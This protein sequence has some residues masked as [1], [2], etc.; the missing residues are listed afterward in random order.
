MSD[1]SDC[2]QSIIWLDGS[3]KAARRVRIPLGAQSNIDTMNQGAWNRLTP[4]QQAAVRS[5][6]N[7]L[8]KAVRK[9]S[10]S[11]GSDFAQ[12]YSVQQRGAEFIITDGNSPL[13]GISHSDRI[14]MET[15]MG[16]VVQ[17]YGR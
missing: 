11:D 1:L 7:R 4:A 5:M 9:S 6:S 12:K 2:S 3:R 10:A 15:L 17:N 16:D 13:V 14:V 8:I